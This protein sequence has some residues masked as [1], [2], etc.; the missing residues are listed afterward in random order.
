[1]GTDGL[2]ARA[3]DQ[4]ARIALPAILA[5]VLVAVGAP[6]PVV[7]QE[8]A[9]DQAYVRVIN[10]SPD[11]GT[12]DVYLD[13]EAV[14][15]GVEYGQGTDFIGL[16][17]GR[18]SLA[19]APAGTSPD[20][21][22]V[23]ATVTLEAGTYSD[24]VAVGPVDEIET[25]LYRVELA[26]I[27]DGNARIRVVH[28]AADLGAFDVALAEDRALFAST[29]YPFETEYVDID[30]G[31]YDFRVLAA[32]SDEI[33][34]GL[35]SVEIEA[36]SVYDIHLIGLSE[37]Q[38]LDGLVL[39]TPVDADA[40]GPADDEDAAT[41]TS[42][43]A[44][45]T[46]VCRC[47]DDAT[48]TPAAPDATET[49][50][51][52]RVPGATATAAAPDAA[53]D[54]TASATAALDATAPVAD[55]SAPAADAPVATAPV[56]DAPETTAPADAADATAPVVDATDSGTRGEESETPVAATDHDGTD[57]AAPEEVE[58]MAPA[59]ADAGGDTTAISDDGTGIAVTDD[60]WTT[61]LD[62]QQPPPS[63]AVDDLDDFGAIQSAPPGSPADDLASDSM[64]QP[65]ADNLATD[66]IA[67]PS[68]ESGL[69]G[70]GVG[71]TLSVDGERATTAMLGALL[72]AIM[73]LGLFLLQPR[74]KRRPARRAVRTRG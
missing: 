4:A 43:G 68:A 58:A 57:P 56:A 39:E 35:P 30:P 48:A 73:T 33:V 26:P 12:V 66:S 22:F 44:G 23:E 71:S 36:G 8:D 29:E 24:L 72:A 13:G 46:P 51:D 55:P 59:A 5:A 64:G 69:P 74:A 70:T 42:D 17:P 34:L 32:D 2:V 63:T 49:A 15:E 50:A 18:G 65:T 20:E 31:T 47:P 53:S 16:P 40:G 21:A 45:A 52:T 60:A 28:N 3:G 14:A 7:A 54:A 9:D 62:T 27:A 11:A 1:M 67:Q 37:D 19:V 38:S 41:P 10:A 61:V 25:Q 6:R